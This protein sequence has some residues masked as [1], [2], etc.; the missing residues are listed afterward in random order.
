MLTPHSLHPPIPRLRLLLNPN[1]LALGPQNRSPALENPLVHIRRPFERVISAADDGR[2]I[3][4][5]HVAGSDVWHFE[6]QTH[7]VAL[8][9][10]VGACVDMGGYVVGGLGAEEG[11]ELF[12]GGGEGFGC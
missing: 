10:E 7:E 6:G 9:Y 3:E 1:W 4:A 8:R 2:A 5:E 11:K 12:D